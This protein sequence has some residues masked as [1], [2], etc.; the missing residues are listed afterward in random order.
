MNR[1][2]LAAAL[3]L[4]LAATRPVPAHAQVTA[5]LIRIVRAGGGWV[6][7]PISGGEASLSSDTVPTLGLT[8]TGCF[9]VWGGHSGE[10]T[11]AARDGVSGQRLDA[12]AIPGEGVPFSVQTEMQSHLDLEV[13][14]SEPRDTVLQLWVGMEVPTRP[15]ACEPV[16]GDGS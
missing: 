4:A 2:L 15:D 5:E 8:L 3:G 1:S 10:W 7:I 12:V 6:A 13:R 14:W 9:T 11:F 16:Y